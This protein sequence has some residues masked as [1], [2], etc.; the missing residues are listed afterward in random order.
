MEKFFTLL[1]LSIIVF[2]TSGCPEQKFPQGQQA[3][4]KDAQTETEK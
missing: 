2:V 1:I 4:P 3:P